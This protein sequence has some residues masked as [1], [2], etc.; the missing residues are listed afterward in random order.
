[1]KRLNNGDCSKQFHLFDQ[2]HFDFYLMK[3]GEK[4]IMYL[5][6]K[7]INLNIYSIFSWKNLTLF[8]LSHALIDIKCL[9]IFK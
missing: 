8:L 4:I 1:M 2:I 7:I 5:F 6:W 3:K 9:H